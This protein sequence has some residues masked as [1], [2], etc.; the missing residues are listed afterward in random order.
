MSKTPIA[1]ALLSAA[2]VVHSAAA[3]RLAAGAD[4]SESLYNEPFYK[5]DDGLWVLMR[6][7]RNDGY[8]CSVS[9]VTT[10]GTYSIHGPIDAEMAKTGT[11]MLWFESPSVPKA[12][13]AEQRV[14]IAFHGDDGTVTWPA[15]LENVS[16][17][18]GT[19]MVAAQI[20]SVLKEKADTNTMSVSLGGT[21]VFHAKVV[22][23]QK[24]YARLGEYIAARAGG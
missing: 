23:I 11:G 14:S 16:K 15:L 19:L 24:A 1:L 6:N 17:A 22:E 21:E 8:R 9:Y 20:A 5:G 3:R 13:G 18:H 7:T 4:K 10:K 2:L 12:T